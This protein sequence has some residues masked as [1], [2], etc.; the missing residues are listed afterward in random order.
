MPWFLVLLVAAATWATT[1]AAT[2]ISAT[3]PLAGGTNPSAG[4]QRMVARLRQLADAADPR[5]N[6]FLSSQ[7]AQSLGTTLLQSHT[8]KDVMAR[9][10]PVFASDLLQSG[11]SEAALKQFGLLENFFSTTAGFTNPVTARGMKLGKAV[12]ALRIGEQENCIVN[13]SPV[14]CLFPLQSGAFHALPRGSRTA[15]PILTN[16]LAADPTDLR[17]RWLLNLAHM[18]LGEWPDQVPEPWR[19]GPEVFASEAPFPPFPQGAGAVG[20]DAV[21]LGGGT[22]L[23]DFDNDG[24]LDVM[25]TSW[26]LRDPLHLYHNNGDGTFSDR[27]EQAGLVGEWG[28]LNLVT[29]DYNNDGF[30]DVLILRGAWLG[31]AGR[32]PN[33]LLRNNGN[34][35]FSDVTEEAGMLSFHPTQTATWFDYDADGWLDVFIGNETQ[36]QDPRDRHPCELYHNNRDGTF[37][38]C[39]ADS[40]VASI[41]WFKA[42]I[43]GD[44]NGDGRPDLF[45]STRENG[46]YLLRNDGPATPL[47][48][49]ARHW[50]F[51]D[52]TREAGIGLPQF[53]FP[54]WFFDYDQDGRLDIFV[55]GYAIQDV[56]DIVAD[57]LGLPTTGERARLY[58][59]RGDGTFADVSYETGVSRVLLAMGSNFGDLDNDGFPDFYLGTGNPDMVT[60]V[61]NRLFWNEDGKRFRDVT[62]AAHMGHLQKGHAGAFADLDNDGDQDVF[63]NMGGAYTGD[64]YQDAFFLNPGFP[65]NRWLK[66]KLEGRTSN[67]SA[68]G[69]RIKVNVETP[70]GARAIYRWVNT[71]GTFG[72]NPLRAEIGLGNATEITSAEVFWPTTG[73]FQSVKGLELDHAYR[74]VEGE[75]AA[76]RL[77]LPKVTFDLSR[78]PQHAAPAPAA[79][80]PERR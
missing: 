49:D 7:R 60:V 29:A 69:A 42:V 52:V 58:R 70:T 11:Q 54:A 78:Q 36:P 66:L 74:V 8:N 15:I 13:H 46:N 63:M 30:T 59:N 21:D 50:K 37:T 32:L 6:P 79:A 62:T 80:L 19:I 18:T 68:I 26:G 47:A 65:T 73:K 44:Y 53:S 43:A 27:T 3:N 31:R 75:T 20:L 51:A 33:S 76:E 77:T 10:G 5:I 9:L 23:E 12:S 41:G 72:A 55:A 40:G 24:L 45:F 35:T 38:E 39:A 16:L 25:V 71:G 22:A 1:N 14:S 34:G 2:P 56:G 17:A 57:Y 61:P 64:V 48:P 4:T 67:R 28:G